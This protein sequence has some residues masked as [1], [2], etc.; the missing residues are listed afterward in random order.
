MNAD[1]QNPPGIATGY[2]LDARV[3]GVRVPVGT[4]FF[5]AS[6][7]PDRFWD[8]SN[9]LSNGY[10]G[11][12]SRGGGGGGA[13]READPTPPT[14]VGGKNTCICTTISPYVNMECW[15]II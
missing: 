6:Y 11:L 3:V 12:L 7:L 1:Y 15:L 13:G 4:R 9:F 14:G 8:P 10:M 5:F 2:G